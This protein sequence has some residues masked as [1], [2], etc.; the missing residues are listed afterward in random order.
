MT[1]G[2]REHETA[3]DRER[4]RCASSA[5]SVGGGWNGSSGPMSARATTRAEAGGGPR[6]CSSA[7]G[8]PAAAVGGGGRGRAAVRLLPPTRQGHGP[9]AR[10]RRKWVALVATEEGRALPGIV[11]AAVSLQEGLTRRVPPVVASVPRGW[12]PGPAGERKPTLRCPRVPLV[13]CAVNDRP[14]RGPRP[15]MRQRR[16]SVRRWAGCVTC[17]ER[18]ARMT[19]GMAR[20]VAQ[21]QGEHSLVKAMTRQW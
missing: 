13:S 3:E 2:R 14:R 10:G 21:A 11:L 4:R 9:Q 1:S 7:W 12:T 8:V 5:A 17:L 6:K 19:L 20:L 18:V 15:P 16:P